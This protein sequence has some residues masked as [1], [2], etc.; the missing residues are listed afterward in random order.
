MNEMTL[1]TRQILGTFF[2]DTVGA[3]ENWPQI[4]L[5]S[6]RFAPLICRVVRAVRWRWALGLDSRW[7]TPLRSVST[8]NLQLRPSEF[9][10]ERHGLHLE[11]NEEEAMAIL[12]PPP[13]DKVARLNVAM[14]EP[15]LM[16]SQDCDSCGKTSYLHV[17]DGAH[18]CQEQGWP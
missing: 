18:G 12:R 13:E 16:C 17:A 8:P 14:Q 15:H 11:I 5:E 1:D 2:R 6:E 4:A 9:P 10:A 3:P 7:G